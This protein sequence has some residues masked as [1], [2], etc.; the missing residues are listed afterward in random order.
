MTT[1]LRKGQI[2][3]TNT[4]EY[5]SVIKDCGSFFVLEYR[6]D[7]YKCDKSYIGK[8]VF[9]IDYDKPR[10]EPPIEEYDRGLKPPPFAQ[11]TTRMR[12]WED[13]VPPGR[14]YRKKKR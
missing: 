7:K 4:G 6:G 1:R 8:S 14:R 3:K 12:Y 9:V 13:Y 10:K 2:L 5:I 11:G